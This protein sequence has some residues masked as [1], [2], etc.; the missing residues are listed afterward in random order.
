VP[1]WSDSKTRISVNG[2][3]AEGEPTPGKFFAV[4]RTWKDGDRLDFEIGMPLR[5]EAVDAQNPDLVALMHG[6]LALF[7]T[8][9]LPT[10]LTRAQLLATSPVASGSDDFVVLTDAGKVINTRSDANSSSARRSASRTRLPA[11]SPSNHAKTA[12][13]SA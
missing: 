9:D 8:G 2:K 11:T 3:L 4:S 1:A 7:G 12:L 6:P 13:D 5:L 10:R